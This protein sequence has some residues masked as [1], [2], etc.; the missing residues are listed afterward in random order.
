MVCYKLFYVEYWLLCNALKVIFQIYE[1]ISF[2]GPKVS[3]GFES[4]LFHEMRDI[5]G[6]NIDILVIYSTL[7]EKDMLNLF[8]ESKIVKNNSNIHIFIIE[9]AVSYLLRTKKGIFAGNEFAK[10]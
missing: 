1:K 2:K 8:M 10:I 6:I 5:F 4:L 3:K 7:M 9:R